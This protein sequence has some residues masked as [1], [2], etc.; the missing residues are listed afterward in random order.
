MNFSCDF[1]KKKKTFSPIT[2]IFELRGPAS[3]TCQSGF[4][5]AGRHSF[6]STGARRFARFSLHIKQGESGDSYGEQNLP[7]N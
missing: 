5:A 1:F 2:A 6:A 4:P 3:W 7:E